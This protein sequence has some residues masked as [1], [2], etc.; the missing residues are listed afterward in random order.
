[1]IYYVM[2]DEEVRERMVKMRIG[3][4]VES[5]HQPVEIWL[6]GERREEGGGEQREGN[7][8]DGYGMRREE[9]SLTGE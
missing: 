2:G 9:G 1:M 3:E 4:R 8:G 5:D 7:N 6:R